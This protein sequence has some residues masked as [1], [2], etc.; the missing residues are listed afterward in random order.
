MELARY[1]GNARM[2]IYPENGHDAWSDTY[3]NPEVFDWLLS[4]EKKE[5]KHMVDNYKDSN[6]YG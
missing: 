6:V 2:T 4:C 3:G 1:G 5:E